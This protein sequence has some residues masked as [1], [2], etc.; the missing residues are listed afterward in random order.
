MKFY[1]LLLIIFV[2]SCKNNQNFDGFDLKSDI[3]KKDSLLKNNE[4]LKYYI[5]TDSI[6]FITGR[7]DSIYY[8]KEFL[9]KVVDTHP[10]LYNDNVS[11]PDINYLCG[12]NQDEF[13]SEVGRD[14]YYMLYAYFLQQKNGISKYKERR[15]NTINI[16]TNINQLFGYINYGGTYFGHQY[17]RILGYAEYSVYSFDFLKENLKN[18]DITKQKDLY[19]KSLKEIIKDEVETDVE[20]K[21]NGNYELRKK[22]RYREL[23][24]IIDSIE[25]LI[26]DFY[27]LRSAQEFHFR[28]YSYN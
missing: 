26:T 11:E 5:R 19:I 23:M 6:L 21:L 20:L 7:G 15:K 1:F 16:Y 14:D 2:F 8:H 13:S 3:K 12:N 28:Y 18:Y 22:E 27:Y 10:E 17:Q 9:N 4:S 25:T 24:P